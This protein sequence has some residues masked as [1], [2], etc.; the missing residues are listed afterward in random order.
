MSIPKYHMA[1]QQGDFIAKASTMGK[2]IV[3]IVPTDYHK[4]F[5]K[6]IGKRLKFHWEDII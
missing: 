2:R 5:Q 3:V 6:V 4:D 1:K